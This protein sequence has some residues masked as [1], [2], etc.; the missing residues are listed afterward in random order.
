MPGPSQ[1]AASLPGGWPDPG[2][3][4]RRPAGRQAGRPGGRA[5]GRRLRGASVTGRWSS[6][7]TGS[8]RNGDSADLRR[9]GH[10]RRRRHPAVQGG[11]ARQ[12]CSQAAGVLD[13]LA[14]PPGPATLE[15]GRNA[16][17]RAGHRCHRPLHAAP[18]RRSSLGTAD[19]G[20][21]LRVPE[22][23]GRAGLVPA[24]AHCVLAAR[25]AGLDILDGVYTHLTRRQP[26]SGR[27]ASQGRHLGFDGKTLIHPGQIDACNEIFGVSAAEA[28]AAA[29]LIAA[30][31]SLPRR[32][33]AWRCLRDDWWSGCT[34]K[35][36]GGSWP[37]TRHDSGSGASGSAG[38]GTRNGRLQQADPG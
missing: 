17:G 22:Q 25:A 24:L 6:A 18:R 33:R 13:E 34:S 15:H 30:W 27:S 8:T 29:E 37:S 38:L 12:R 36:R 7:S 16:A 1:K 31:E 32:G 28:A 2:P 21:A 9:G 26:A 23:P 11:R 35:K 20:K 10:Q 5:R 19:L 14:A 3:G 4:G